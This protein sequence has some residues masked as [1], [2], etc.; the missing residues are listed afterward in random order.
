MLNFNIGVKSPQGRQLVAP[1]SMSVHE[2]EKIAI[3]GEEG[4]G[5]SLFLKA[6]LNHPSL[7]TL[8]VTRSVSS[9]VLFGYVSQD[10]AAEDL[11]R[12]SR[13]YIIED[14]WER[15]ESFGS[16]HQD[17]LP[18]FSEDDFD[19]PLQSLSGGERVRIQLMKILVQDVDVFLLDEP[20]ND[21]DIETLMWLESWILSQSK[22]ILYISHDVKLLKNTANR[23]VHFEQTHRKTR[24]H[25]TV[26]EGT[27]DDYVE[28]RNLE[29]AT[30]NHQVE[31]DQ[32][33]RAK[34]YDRWLQ[35]YQT[36]EHRQRTQTRQDPAK[37]RLLKKKMKT[38][39]STE[40][41][42]DRETHETKIDT[43]S[44][45]SIRF[46][47]Q[48]KVHRK[49]IAEIDVDALEV[50]GKTLGYNFY[51]DIYT[52]DKIAIIGRNG[53]GKSSLLKQ[54]FENHDAMMHQDYRLNL[55]FEKSPIDNCVREGSRE[56][57][58]LITNRLGSLKFTETEMNTPMRLLSGGQKAKVSLLKLV[59]QKPQFII[60]DE[61]TR[62]LSP[63][64]VHEIYSMLQ[65]F[66][67]AILCV[68]HDR[69]LIENV[70]DTVIVMTEDG[71]EPVSE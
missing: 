56:E 52:P 31:R 71:F 9:K 16:V 36:V 70:F 62:N 20:T 60:L 5:K 18:H 47:N 14:Q 8:E 10:I 13:D 12:S 49:K 69:S 32:A 17:L 64:S 34:R 28:T 29:I 57:R 24:S 58:G 26:F 54:V 3:I 61:P 27:Y 35:L 44:A 7:D 33:A 2:N 39:K 37:G 38:I 19:R 15:Y 46:D 11:L 22:P 21:L 25:I 51:L 43:E 23:V 45:I 65:G 1:F 41:R 55:D 4:N 30:H 48:E 42:F 68:T 53:I 6:L 63:L 66:Q 67:G 50:A 40:R 59:L